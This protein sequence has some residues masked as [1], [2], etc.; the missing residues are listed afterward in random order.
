MKPRA[1]IG[2]HEILSVF[3][4]VE[5]CEGEALALAP[6]LLESSREWHGS[7]NIDTQSTLFFTV[8]LNAWLLDDRVSYADRPF[9]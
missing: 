1:W 9:V 2:G 4:G 7:Q 5:L 8:I 3:Y 6:I